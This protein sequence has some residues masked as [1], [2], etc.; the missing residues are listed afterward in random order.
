MSADLPGRYP[1][2]Q[3]PREAALW[4]SSPGY[5]PDWERVAPDQSLLAVFEREVAPLHGMVYARARPAALKS[6]RGDN[7][8]HLVAPFSARGSAIAYKD[9]EV[10][11]FLVLVFQH[12]GSDCELT[13][14]VEASD[15]AA[16]GRGL[17]AAGEV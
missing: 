12:S 15:G 6:I 13:P 9:L 3:K 10:G 17:I 1:R 14:N 8:R 2:R 7:D 11:P 5:D 4:H 16:L